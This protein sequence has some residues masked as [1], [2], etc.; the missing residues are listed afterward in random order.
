MSKSSWK[1]C[2]NADEGELSRNCQITSGQNYLAIIIMNQ[3]LILIPK[4]IV[5]FLLNQSHKI[6]V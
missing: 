3:C 6:N 2:N 1:Y 4:V 5:A